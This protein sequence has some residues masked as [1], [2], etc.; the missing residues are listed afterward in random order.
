MIFIILVFKI[1]LFIFAK[2]FLKM[3]SN[4]SIIAALFLCSLGMS[5]QSK[6][7]VQSIKDMTGCY[8]VT[9]NFAETFSQ[10]KDYVRKPTSQSHAV[11]WV[12]VAE[13][14]PGKIE[15]QHILI[16]DPD[17]EGKDAIV[18][19][20]RQD[21]IYQNTDLYLYDKDNHWT[22][23]KLSPKDVKGQWTQIVYQVDDAPRYSGSGT[24]VHVDGKNYWEN[25]ADAPLP[26]R[27]KT[28]RNDYNVM[29]RTNRQEIFDWGW[30][31]FQDN[32]KL[33]REDGKPDQ[34]I[35]EEIG[36]D[37][38]RKTD[39]AKCAK[40]VAYWKDY[41]SLWKTV[42]DTWQTRMDQKKDLYVLPAVK[43]THL[44]DALMKLNPKQNKEAK[45]LVNQYILDKK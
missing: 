17:G 18:K 7:D 36:K 32:K 27:D 26:R 29:N 37:Y 22:Y 14:A 12:T 2:N 16:A 15:L 6:Q 25:N 33:V 3:K 20:W 19:H 24:W 10:S 28:K 21:W 4:K 41:A 40:A 31:H 30:L 23:K 1:F 11:E 35:T 45:V 13:E 38:Y 43:D 8:D 34:L 9:F 5:A 39:N 44:Y 42:R